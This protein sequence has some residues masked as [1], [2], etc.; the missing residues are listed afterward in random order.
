M[1]TAP[2][3]G[4]FRGNATCGLDITSR[5]PSV[6]RRVTPSPRAPPGTI[7]RWRPSHRGRTRPVG[8]SAINGWK[9]FLSMEHLV[10]L[11]DLAWPVKYTATS[12]FPSTKSLCPRPEPPVTAGA[13]EERVDDAPNRRAKRLVMVP[14]PLVPLPL[15]DAHSMM[16]I[17]THTHGGSE[18][19]SKRLPRP[20]AVAQEPEPSSRGPGVDGLADQTFSDLF[21][22][23]WSF[24]RR[25]LTKH[26]E[27]THNDRRRGDRGRHSRAREPAHQRKT[28]CLI[29]DH[30]GS[31]PRP[32]APRAF[33]DPHRPEG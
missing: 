11:S 14:T 20:I 10:R 17:N 3:T 12:G 1:D 26:D 13:R 29:H 19:R 23:F 27:P 30:D 21:R 7:Q 5:P 31:T 33:E 2:A 6:T 22:C 9:R 32:G 4:S 15:D 28:P 25:T 18:R 8:T 16:E 24:R